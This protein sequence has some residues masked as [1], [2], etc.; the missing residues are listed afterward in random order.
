MADKTFQEM[1]K[2]L[3]PIMRIYERQFGAGIHEGTLAFL[4]ASMLAGCS[5]NGNECASIV[6]HALKIRAE[7]R[8]RGLW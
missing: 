4:I 2:D 8:E 7:F 1:I 5:A 6:D 3:D